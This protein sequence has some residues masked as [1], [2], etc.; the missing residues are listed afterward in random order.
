MSSIT[1]IVPALNEESNLE[2][3]VRDILPSLKRYFQEFEVLIFDD[4]SSDQTGK[5]ADQIASNIPQVKAIHNPKTMGFGYNYRKGVEMAGKDYILMIPGDNEITT[6]SYE[7]MF[8]KV[9]EKDMIIPH[10]LNTEIRPWLRRFLSKI[11]TMTNNFLFRTSLLYFNGPVLHKRSLIQ[12]I[13]IQTDSFAYQTELLVKMIR[14][15]Y[16]YTETGMWLKE[17]KGKSKAF[18][19]KNVVRTIQSIVQL[20]FKVYF[21]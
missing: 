13:G 18:R 14:K 2:S 1:V 5:I 20:F 10:T 17:R 15:G 19:L 6:E 21:K 11:Y 16:T 8:Q 7:V 3:A 12:A 4:G 9:G